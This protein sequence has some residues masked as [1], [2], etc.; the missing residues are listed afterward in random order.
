MS[1]VCIND[2]I[3]EVSKDGMIKHKCH[4]NR[5]YTIS[6]RIGKRGYKVVAI[7]NRTLRKSYYV[8]R[9]LA[10]AF[11]PNPN[12]L[13]EV[14]HLDGNKLNNNLDNLK[15]GTHYDNMSD[16]NWHH[17]KGENCGASKLTWKIV[18]VIRELFKRKTPV[19]G[20]RLAEYFGVKQPTISDIKRGVTWLEC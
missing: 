13:P 8:H 6:P 11:L 16:D 20:V 18:K 19:T 10:I 12:N 5:I 1:K 3:L 9:L 4:D 2:L 15:W 14:R 7:R 17:N